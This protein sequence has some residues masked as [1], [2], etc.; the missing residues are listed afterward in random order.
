MKSL[1]TL[2]PDRSTSTPDSG[3]PSAL[4]DCSSRSRNAPSRGSAWRVVQRLAPCAAAAAALLALAPAAAIPA[5]VQSEISIG[6]DDAIPL[7]IN[8][9]QLRYYMS[10]WPFVDLM[11]GAK[12]WGT[13]SVVPGW[14]PGTG[15]IDQIP[16][17]AWGQ[18]LRYRYPPSH[19]GQVDRPD[20][21]SLGPNGED[22]NGSGDDI[23]NWDVQE[24][25]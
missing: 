14:G 15:L 6:S 13:L 11:K 24:E 7:G 3:E 4:G 5:V 17:D 9:N 21:W 22:D 8:L 20:V 1:I 18:T 12:T 19:P 16:T 10:S 2:T 23:N 25:A